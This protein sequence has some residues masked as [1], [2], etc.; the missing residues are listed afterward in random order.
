M[1]ITNSGAIVKAVFATGDGKNDHNRRTETELQAEQVDAV[2]V[3]IQSRLG[4]G[5]S[6]LNTT[7]PPLAPPVLAVP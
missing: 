3:R 5:P 4:T 1:A 7:P 2:A 6:S